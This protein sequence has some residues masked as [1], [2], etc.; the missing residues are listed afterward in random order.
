MQANLIQ[1]LFP[2]NYFD[3]QSEKPLSF[4]ELPS[5]DFLCLLFGAYHYPSS[6]S[7]SRDYLVTLY[8]QSNCAGKQLEVIYVSADRTFKEFK[9]HVKHMPWVTL[10]HFCPPA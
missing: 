8:H 5:S 4:A 7:F 3:C 6:L 9:A 10:P 1:L 2:L